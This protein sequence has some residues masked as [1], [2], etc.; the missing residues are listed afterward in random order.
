MV[1]HAPVSDLVKNLLLEPC[2]AFAS[3]VAFYHLPGSVVLDSRRLM[4]LAM[5]LGSHEGLVVGVLVEDRAVGQVELGTCHHSGGDHV[6]AGIRG[7]GPAIVRARSCLCALA[8]ATSQFL[9]SK[10]RGNRGWV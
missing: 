6:V 1:V 2:D 7:S 9:A 5:G 4:S 8:L 3:A 10:G